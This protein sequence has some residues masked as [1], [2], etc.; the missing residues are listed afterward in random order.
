MTTL[1]LLPWYTPWHPS[2]DHDPLLPP[3]GGA[4]TDKVGIIRRDG[5]EEH[6][7]ANDVCWDWDNQWCGGRDD[8]IAFFVKNAATLKLQSEYYAEVKR[9]YGFL[10]GGQCD[11]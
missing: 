9:S 5:V 8:I 2:D 3:P 11:V 7:V 4:L 6:A 1:S 10:L